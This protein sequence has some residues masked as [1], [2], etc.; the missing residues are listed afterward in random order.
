[1][2][3]G[4]FHGYK[5][6]GSF[7]SLVRFVFMIMITSLRCTRTEFNLDLVSRCW[8]RASRNR[9]RLDNGRHDI[10]HFFFR[11]RRRL[12]C[13]HVMVPFFLRARKKKGTITSMIK[14]G[15][16]SIVCRAS[17]VA[18]RTWTTSHK[19]PGWSSLDKSINTRY[20]ST[21]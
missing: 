1:M 12:V 14:H 16:T 5:N 15:R 7:P 19:R 11:W 10:Q 4:E 6:Q 18:W 3:I 8:R 20:V 17:H 9:I 13:A 2:R 21:W